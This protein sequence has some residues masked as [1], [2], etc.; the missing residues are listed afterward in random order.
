MIL[1]STP[2]GDSTRV[3]LSVAEV[4]S[5][6]RQEVESVARATVEFHAVE[7]MNRRIEAPTVPGGYY[8][9]CLPR[10]L[11]LASPG[12]PLEE[13][14]GVD[15]CK[16]ASCSKQKAKSADASTRATAEFLRV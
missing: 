16:F 2:F 12:T 7:R 3:N 9:H 10:A 14:S 5:C 6:S 13:L 11:G 15:A 4:A 1:D 8:F